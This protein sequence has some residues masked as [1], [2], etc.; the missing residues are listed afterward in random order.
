MPG[1][2]PGNG[3]MI[4]H[5]LGLVLFA[6]FDV[7]PAEDVVLQPD[8]LYLSRER[9]SLLREECR[10]WWWRCS[11]PTRGAA[12]GCKKAGCTCA[13]ESGSTG[14]LTPPLKRWRCSAPT[15]RAGFCRSVRAGR[16]PHIPSAPRIY[17][18]RGRNFPP[19]G[20]A[21]AATVKQHQLCK[22]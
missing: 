12:T 7:V 14:W 5:N 6:P 15:K 1:C 9:F 8:V 13:T 22:C 21:D 4:L 2:S 10:T 18:H 3:G 16:F 20:G 11:H 17:R 19:A